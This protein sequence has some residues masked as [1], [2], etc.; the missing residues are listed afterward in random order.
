MRGVPLAGLAL[1]GSAT[2]GPR[3]EE[4]DAQTTRSLLKPASS[5][6]WNPGACQAEAPT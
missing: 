4:P 2:D 6:L 3:C 1:S 5:G